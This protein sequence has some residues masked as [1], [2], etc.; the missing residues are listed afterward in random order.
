[1][2]AHE[3]LRQDFL[4]RDK[5]L[6]TPSNKGALAAL[7]DHT[8]L[9]PDA[10]QADFVDLLKQ[11]CE[12]GFRAVCLPSSRIHSAAHDLAHSALRAS[13][14]LICTVIG[15]PH[16]NSM[17][18]AKAA[19]ITLSRD[20]GAH[21]FDYVQNLGWVREQNWTQLSTEAAALVN[22]ARGGLVK[23]ILETSFLSEEDIFNSALA[24]ARGGVHV[25][26]TSTG[27]GNRGAIEK[28]VQILSRVAEQIK[29]ERGYA[30]GIKASGGIKTFED[31]LKMIRAGATRLG[32]SG[33]VQLIEGQR[34]S[35][36]TY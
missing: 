27:F 22:S 35:A 30:I 4:T 9:K 3:H 6:S 10:R 12:F 31:S 7:I 14:P 19:E 29:T 34:L 13:Q 16:G 21:E 5:L 32:T 2:F 8:L 23:V 24:A 11:A 1:M 28:D 26:K 33:G 15:F 25:L 17:T 18:D 20:S 36:E